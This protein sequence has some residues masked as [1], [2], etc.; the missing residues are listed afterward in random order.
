MKIVLLDA[1]TLGRDTDLG[2]FASFGEFIS[3]KT[4]K[5]GRAHV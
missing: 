1:D 5:I 2:A 3:Y 4:T